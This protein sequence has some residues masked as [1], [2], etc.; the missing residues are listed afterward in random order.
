MYH[1]SYVPIRNV[2]L[3]LFLLEHLFTLGFL[4]NA[5]CVDVLWIFA[6][7]AYDI[8]SANHDVQ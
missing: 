7:K 1:P 8:S 2:E 5:Q 3:S 6:S 4:I